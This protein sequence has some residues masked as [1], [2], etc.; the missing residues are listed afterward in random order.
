MNNPALTGKVASVLQAGHV[1]STRF[2]PFE[3]HV[4]FLLQVCSCAGLSSAFRALFS[5]ARQGNRVEGSPGGVVDVL[6]F[7]RNCCAARLS[8]CASV[9]CAR[10]EYG[11]TLL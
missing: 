3:S 8:C 10:L 6:F 2:Q 11:T 4:P 9:M 5:G 1:L 7:S